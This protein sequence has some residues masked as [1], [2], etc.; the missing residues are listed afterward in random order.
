M[1][2]IYQEIEQKIKSNQAVVLTTDLTN[3]I[4][5]DT[6]LL[7]KLFTQKELEK[8]ENQSLLQ[9]LRDGKPALIQYNKEEYV[10]AEPFYP[11]ER[12]IVLGGGHIALPLVEM[13]AKVGFEVIIV[14]DRPSFANSLRFPDAKEVICEGFHVC[15]DKI[16]L[17]RNDYIVIIT[18]GHRHDTLCLR[19][20][21]KA[22]ESIYVGMIGSKRRVTIVKQELI[23]E[24]FDKERLERVCTPIGLS[25]GAATPE[26]IS[27]SILAQLIKRKRLDNQGEFMVNRSD[28]D[29]YLLGT[30]ASLREDK[31]CMVSVIETKGSVPR[32]VGSKM[33]VY[34]TGELIGS[35]GGGCSE[36][37]IMRKAL[38][39]IGTKKWTIETIDMTN[40]VA[41]EEGMVCGGVMTV[42]LEDV[43]L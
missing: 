37:A 36:S 31:C 25:I 34:K 2:N 9:V 22:P 26:E 18:R 11:K 1:P 38:E 12:L 29:S 19:H 17:T 23:E 24:G 16:K 15:F 3:Q 39:L 13:A 40:E 14:D 4:G 5:D 30:L 41:E 32:G 35:I 43:I 8:E 42:L 28:L 20:I 7:K 6:I 33:L 10:L 27:V 21:L